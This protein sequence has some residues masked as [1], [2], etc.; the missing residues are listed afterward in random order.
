ECLLPKQDVVGSN[1]ITRSRGVRGRLAAGQ[2]A[3]VSATTVNTYTR[4]IK[5]FF[6]R[7]K[8]EDIIKTDPLASVPTPKLPQRLP[9]VTTEE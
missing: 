8:R 3:K 6:S 5:G 2:Q 7:L 4:A 9:K 1:P